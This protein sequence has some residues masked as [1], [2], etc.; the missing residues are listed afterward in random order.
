MAT[1][2]M[3]S[4]K[5]TESDAFLDMPTSAQCLYF[6]INMSAD[7]DGFVGNVKTIKRMVGSSDDD[8]RLLMAKEFL[9]PFES[10]VVVIRDWKIHNYIQKDRYHETFYKSE[11]S[12]LIER[13]NK[14]YQRLETVDT[15][16]IQ[17]VSKMD[18]Q[19]RLGKS[20]VRLGK[21]RDNMSSSD[22]HD[23]GSAIPYKKIIDYLNE[24]ANASYRSTTK[25][26]QTLIKARFAEGFTEK[27]F[28]K[29]IDIKTQ[30][31]LNN[32]KMNKYLRPETLFGTKFEGYLNERAI[33]TQ[34]GGD[35]DKLGF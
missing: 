5:I 35:Y 23:H 26:T 18:T 19:V 11:K 8:L 21:D 1:R 4:R 25:K 32:S 3:F 15:E 29:V 31:W 22:E 17:D 24:K 34:G 30:A 9:I 14:Q 7:D 20:K 10:G 28:Y 13:E 6:H 16:C 27:D 12:E 2:R 33:D